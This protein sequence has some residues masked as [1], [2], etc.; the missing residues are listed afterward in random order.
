[1]TVTPRIRQPLQQHQ[2]DTLAPACSVG[3]GREGLAPAVP[4]QAALQV[5]FQKRTGCGHHGDPAGQRQRTFA[6]AQRLSGEVDGHQ[7]GGA[8]RVDG[9]C[10][11]LQPEDV[12]DP[13]GRDAAR[14]AVADVADQGFGALGA[15]GKQRGVVVVHQA[16][17]HAGL[18]APQRRRIDAGPLQHLPRGLQQQPLLRVHRR[19]LTRAD[20]EEARVE[21]TRVVEE[22]A[23]QGG[24]VVTR[25]EHQVPAAV[26]G[27]SG[28]GVAAGLQQAPEVL[29]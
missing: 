10:R 13:A 17:E 14:V 6:L 15:G 7:G 16:R 8:G 24:V 21:L 11:A 22:A 4:G 25:S 19:R 9:D 5:E 29:R 18:A 26:V 27:E 3:R 23:V 20:A 28:H 2:T 12:R 1:M